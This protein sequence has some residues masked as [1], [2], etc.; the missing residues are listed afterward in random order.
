MA[1]KNTN[2]IRRGFAYF[3]RTNLPTKQYQFIASA[4]DC[5][6]ELCKEAPTTAMLDVM[7]NNLRKNK[8]KPRDIVMVDFGDGIAGQEVQDFITKNPD[9]FHAAKHLIYTSG[10]HKKMFA[11]EDFETIVDMYNEMVVA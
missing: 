10:T 5:P 1:K 11:F 6:A 2:G 3:V 9:W 4:V 8:F 7:L